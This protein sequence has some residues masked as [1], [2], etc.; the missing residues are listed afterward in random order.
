[1]RRKLTNLQKLLK[2]MTGRTPRPN[3]IK[4]LIGRHYGKKLHTK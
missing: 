2:E 1:M 4:E 3:D